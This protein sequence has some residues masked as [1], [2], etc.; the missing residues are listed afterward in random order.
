MGKTFPAPGGSPEL[1]TSPAGTNAAELLL[2]VWDQLL[3]YGVAVG[4]QIGRIHCVRIVVI[5]IGV[6]DL[7]DQHAREVG[8]GP[9]LK[10]IVTVRR[11]HAVARQLSRERRLRAE[12]TEAGGKMTLVDGQGIADVGVVVKPCRKQDI[13]PDVCGPTPEPG[14]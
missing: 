4:A 7:H 14:Q 9:L 8:T 12:F 3:N 10:E 6:L 2:D 13:R 11:T 5:R 1:G